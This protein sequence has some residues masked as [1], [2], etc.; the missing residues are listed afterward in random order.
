VLI[1]PFAKLLVI[2]FIVEVG[3]GAAAFVGDEEDMEGKG[4]REMGMIGRGR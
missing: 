3:E 4:E 2:G 1:S